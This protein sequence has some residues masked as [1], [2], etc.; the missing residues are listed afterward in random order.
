MIAVA[1][2]RSA[3]SH[4]TMKLN[5]GLVLGASAT[6]ALAFVPSLSTAAVSTK[7]AVNLRDLVSTSPP[8]RS[9]ATL[10]S[11]KKRGEGYGPPLENIS[12]AVGNTP[13]IKISDRIAPAGR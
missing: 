2:R 11:A 8:A 6:S 10:M 3:L 1:A 13:M 4:H 7:L 12:E 9:M 5:I